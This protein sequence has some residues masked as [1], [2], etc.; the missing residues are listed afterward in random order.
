[1][2]DDPI[3]DEAKRAQSSWREEAQKRRGILSRGFA[4]VLRRDLTASRRFT[5]AASHLTRLAVALPT[6]RFRG[7]RSV[8]AMASGRSLG[9]P[10]IGRMPRPQSP[11]RT[12]LAAALANEFGLTPRAVLPRV[13]ALIRGAIPLR[14]E[15]RLYT[16]RHLIEFDESQP[17]GGLEM[18]YFVRLQVPGGRRS[19]IKLGRSRVPA[20]RL[21]EHRTSSPYPLTLLACAPCLLIAERAVHDAFAYARLSG[22]WFSPV[23]RLERLAGELRALVGDPTSHSS[24]TA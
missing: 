10:Y 14:D 8:A 23:A 2:V 21:L 24:V 16:L 13:D 6:S 9:V 1:M 4:V 19:P 22:E 12:L 15:L 11:L 18:T 3:L 20:A 17:W 7:V 5:R